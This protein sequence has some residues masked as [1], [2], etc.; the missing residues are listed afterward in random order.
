MKKLRLLTPLLISAVWLGV[1]LPGSTALARPIDDPSTALSAP[2]LSVQPDVFT[3]LTEVATPTIQTRTLNI[4]NATPST[5]LTWTIVVT[6]SPAFT[7]TVKP[8][9]GTNAASVTVQIDASPIAV[10]GTY[11]ASLIITADPTTT[12]GSPITIPINVI[13]VDRLYR[14]YLPV[15]NKS[16]PPPLTNTGTLTFGLA[17]V[18]SAEAPAS[19]DRYQHAMTLSAT[20]NR[21]PMYWPNIET[22]PITQPRVFDWSKQ[23]ANIIADINHGMTDVPILMLTPIGLDTAGSRTAPQPKVG[24]GLRLRMSGQSINSITAPSSQG[25]PPQGLTLSVFTDSTDTPGAGKAINPNNR[26]AYFV[27]AAV[28][29]FMPGG[30]LAQARGWTNGQGI[31]YWEIWNEEDLDQFF[32]GTSTDYA[33]LLKVAYLSAKQ[34]DPNA[35]IVFG[36][37]AHFQRPNWLDGV[38]NVIATDPVSTTYH[39]FMDA[40]ASHNYAWAWQTF[41][42]LYQDRSRLD[43]HGL[44]NVKL[45]LTETGVPVCDDPAPLANPPLVPFCPSP[46]R[47]TMSEQADFVIQTMTYAAWLNTEVSIWFNLYDDCGNDSSYDAF[48]LVR[49]PPITSLCPITVRPATPRDGTPRAS[50]DAYT[51]TIQL[52]SGAQPYWRDRRTGTITDWTGGNQEIFAFKHPSSGQ[53]VV[54]MWTRYYVTDTVT[55]T[56]T[57]SWALLILPDGT[58]STIHPTNG[59][60]TIS[61]SAATNAMTPTGDGSAP[62]GGSPRIV[63][64]NDPAVTP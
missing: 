14:S 37:M 49:N 10:T 21:W 61:L 36:G 33:R 50:F 39:G 25:S 1:A 52:L 34:A 31:R 11:T 62:I 38:L 63:V 12:V 6:P 51:T 55:L 15:M 46:L 42:Y 17:F 13:A 22:H 48:G 26:W 28:T 19:N 35:T 30:V 27:N 16:N 64:E 47:A 2:I 57:S 44:T 9:S 41:G 59:V 23:D 56:A 29:R 20:F 3:L 8:I 5:V 32:S 4:A 40:V 7:P 24:D 45:W 54:A 43:N 58:S 60:Y 53:R 18:S